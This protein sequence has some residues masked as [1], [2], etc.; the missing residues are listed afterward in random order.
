M[1]AALAAAASAAAAADAGKHPQIVLQKN[2][3]TTVALFFY[4]PAII[5]LLKLSLTGNTQVAIATAAKA[6]NTKRCVK[7]LCIAN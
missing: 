7:T 2:R 4:V 5:P 6:T 1:A 3:A